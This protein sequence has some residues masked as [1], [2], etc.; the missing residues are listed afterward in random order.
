MADD[1][2]VLRSRAGQP[3]TGDWRKDPGLAAVR[4]VYRMCKKRKRGDSLREAIETWEKDRA[5]TGPEGAVPAEWAPKES[6]IRRL[7][8]GRRPK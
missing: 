4:R 5:A 1:F 8:R 7:T 2:D 6:L 3:L